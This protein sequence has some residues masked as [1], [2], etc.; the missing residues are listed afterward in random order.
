MKIEKIFHRM[1]SEVIKIQGLDD[2][3]VLTD[4][5]FFDEVPFFTRASDVSFLERLGRDGAEKLLIEFALEYL[6]NL[7]QHNNSRS[8]MLAAITI[9]DHGKRDILVP[10]IFVCN[11]RI[12]DLAENRFTLNA[13]RSAFA[14]K[15]TSL[16]GQCDVNGHH[17]IFEDRKSISRRVRVFIGEET[18]PE[19]MI[20]VANFAAIE[21]KTNGRHGISSQRVRSSR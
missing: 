4:V 10:N 14:E 21:G 11:G 1:L 9:V 17:Q 2:L 15:I 8:D 13:P 16:V 5:D 20:Q 19:G 3:S 7:I 12:E 6:R 18:L